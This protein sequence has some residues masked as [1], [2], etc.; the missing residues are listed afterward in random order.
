MNGSVCSEESKP[1]HLTTAGCAQR[2][3]NETPP[4][5]GSTSLVAHPAQARSTSSHARALIF[6]LLQHRE[7]G[8]AAHGH[9]AHLARA[10]DRHHDVELVVA[11]EQCNVAD[12]GP[13]HRQV[14]HGPGVA[15]RIELDD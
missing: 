5:L 14:E 2:S 9:H 4:T 7:L 13:A 3:S 8:F 6:C 12:L 15:A 1:T 10:V 11:L